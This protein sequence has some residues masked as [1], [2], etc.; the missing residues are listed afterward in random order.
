MPAAMEGA[1]LT[2]GTRKRPRKVREMM[3]CCWTRKKRLVLMRL[4]C[5]N[6]SIG[7]QWFGR[8]K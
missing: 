1:T 2:L 4:F 7:A 6:F 5:S 3:P 8:H